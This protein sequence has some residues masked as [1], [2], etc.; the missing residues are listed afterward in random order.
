[1]MQA[2]YLDNAATT[3]LAPAV[4]SAMQTQLEKCYANPAS[5]HGPGRNAAQVVAQ[6]RTQ[7]ANLIQARPEEIVWTSGATEA[8]NLAIKGVA[9]FH[10]RQQRK[11]GHIITARTEHK[12][13][14]DPVRDL[15]SRG[16]RVTW[17]N[18]DAG[19][20]IDVPALAQVLTHDTALIS[21]MHVNNEIGVIQD[22]SAIARLA[23][24]N[25]ITLHVDAAQSL[26]KLPIDVDAL[27]VDLLSMSAHKL[28]GPKGVGALYV[29]Q[30]PK[31]RLLAQIQGGGHEQGLRSGTLAPHQI[32]GFA[33][34]CTLAGSDMA[35]EQ[36]RIATLR[37]DLWGKLKTLP[38]LIRNGN[39]EKTVAGILNISVEGV[40]GEA[41]LAAVT[42]GE[43]ALAVSSGSACS[44]ARAE[45]SYVLRALGRTPELAGASLRLSLGRFSTQADVDIAAD[46]IS[47]EVNRL[48][49]LSPLWEVSSKMQAA[50]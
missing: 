41:L 26:G 4:L 42:G 25:D 24:E 16:W 40:D 8:N 27:G 36:G 18:V 15:E 43:Q 5:T 47:W 49:A 7:V 37:N 19:G 33:A 21:V 20:R 29:R 48:R 3:A 34:A 38:G 30:R 46:K 11:P 12:A 45:S 9:D 39:G 10:H 44:A 6:A 35:E 17:L 14:I 2:I 50:S 22:I 13:V 23:R 32:V 28:H 1:M 31:A